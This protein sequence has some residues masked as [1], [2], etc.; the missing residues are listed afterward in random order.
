MVAR[1]V[2][3]SR[4]RFREDIVSD[5]HWHPRHGVQD[6]ND[7][8]SDARSLCDK[9][10][11]N[12]CP[13]FYKPALTGFDGQESRVWTATSRIAASNAGTTSQAWPSNPLFS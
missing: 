13:N 12:T 4:Y 2:L 7:T 8:L 9:Q 6:G 10:L 1:I 3:P 11:D 5:E